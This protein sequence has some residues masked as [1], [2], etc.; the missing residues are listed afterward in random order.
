V[1]SEV[2]SLSLRLVPL[3]GGSARPG[4]ATASASGAIARPG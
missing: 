1:N 4:G 3:V 2:P